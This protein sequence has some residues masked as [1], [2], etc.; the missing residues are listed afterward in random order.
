MRVA[1]EHR[2]DPTGSR[3]HDVS[4]SG[5]SV[6]CNH[7]P[8]TPSALLLDHVACGAHPYVT[9]GRPVVS[10]GTSDPDGDRRTGQ[11]AFWPVAEPE[12]HGDDPVDAVQGRLLL[13]PR[14]GRHRERGAPTRGR[15]R[16]G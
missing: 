11:F 7:P 16:S 3:V 4:S 12:R 2:G 13:P 15:T 10:A 5:L 9:T 6:T 14:R 8:A 1:E